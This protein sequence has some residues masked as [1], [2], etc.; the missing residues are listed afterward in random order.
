MDERKKAKIHFFEN[1]KNNNGL[2]DDV[3]IDTFSYIDLSPKDIFPWDSNYPFPLSWLLNYDYNI[4]I[5]DFLKDIKENSKKI[6]IKNKNSENEY[7][8]FDCLSIEDIK[9][10]F[11]GIKNAHNLIIPEI[12]VSNEIL[13][14]EIEK[15]ENEES[16]DPTL[17]V[18]LNAGGTT[19]NGEELMYS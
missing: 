11:V 4:T 19:L 3:K 6:K 18:R 14:N 5:E 17:F 16:Q 12:L 13:K 15:I 8:K 7:I 9:P 2:N 1:K 10:I